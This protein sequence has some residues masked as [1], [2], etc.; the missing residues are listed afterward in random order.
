MRLPR[1]TEWLLIPKP[2]RIERS[3]EPVVFSLDQAID[4]I[5]REKPLIWL[6][7][8]FSVPEPSGL[9][10]GYALT[11]S[12]LELTFKGGAAKSQ[13][14]QIIDTVLPRWP[15]EAL[16]DE[17]E[18]LDFDLSESL[19][20]FFKGINDAVAPNTLH[21]AVVSYYQQGLARRPLCITTNWDTL[22]ETAFRNAGY[23]VVIGGPA[24]MPDAAFGK[25]GSDPR[26]IFLY[27]PHG[28]F[29]TQDVVCSLKREQSQLALNFEIMRHP[30]LFLG[31]SGYEPS[32]YR[33]LE[34]SAGQLWCIRDRDDFEIPAKRRL[35]TKPNTFVYVGDVRELLRALG[36]LEGD[37]GLTSKYVALD[38]K[39]PPKIIEVVRL[40]I[41][42]S[43][44]PDFC[45][46]ALT[47]TLMSFHDEPEA[48]IRF[49]TLMRATINHM[50]NRMNHP[51]VPL[52]LLGSSRFRDSEQTWISLLA[53]LL[54]TS[55]NLPSRIVDQLIRL[56]DE[57][58]KKAG[59]AG[60]PEDQGVYM[61]GVLLNRT[62]L[63]KSYV[64]MGDK[65]DD[66][67][68][69][70]VAALYGSD[71]A[72]EGENIELLAFEHLREGQKEQAQNCFDYAATS[73]YLRG[74]WN[75]GRQN[76]WA[77]NN[78]E[79]MMDSARENTLLIPSEGN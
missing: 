63:Y 11:R 6:G 35:L 60:S 77:A 18:F 31:Y 40:S 61:P 10:S 72:A 65:V 7:S 37:V 67:K 2:F 75:A 1:K 55:R 27:H 8:I 14:D 74:L 38:G 16:L 43:L 32:L 23:S 9:P 44:S 70:I 57:A 26:T 79:K 19:L 54:R 36:V 34:F 47:E 56:A 24:E 5:K 12:L 33:R 28:S 45:V 48:T 58:G 78:I 20:T 46:D 3:A 59:D 62:K 49:I 64:R 4:W 53:C 71:M 42:A 76:E 25:E 41:F 29:E 13:E 15:L 21:K 51:G 68:L 17:F 73:F 52:A 22:Q 69:Y 30:T 50:R 39:I 66:E